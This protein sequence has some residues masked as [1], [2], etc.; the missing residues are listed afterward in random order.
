M[1]YPGIQSVIAIAIGIQSYTVDFR[2]LVPS[3]KKQIQTDQSNASY[4]ENVTEYGKFDSSVWFF[5]FS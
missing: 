3:R 1:V 5:I 2:L 4:T